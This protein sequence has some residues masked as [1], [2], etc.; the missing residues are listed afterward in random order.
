MLFLILL[1][2]LVYRRIG[3]VSYIKTIDC[4]KHL[5]CF[6]YREF[7]KTAIFNIRFNASEQEKIQ[8]LCSEILSFLHFFLVSKQPSSQDRFG[9]QNIVILHNA[10]T[11]IS[12]SILK[13]TMNYAFRSFS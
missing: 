3:S 13:N 1:S 7:C 10:V 5:F 2:A 8:Y 4:P 11:M 12:R 9:Q 6:L